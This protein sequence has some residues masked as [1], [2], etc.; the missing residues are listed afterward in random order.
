[1]IK[2][3]ELYTDSKDILT[4]IG[5]LRN[6]NNTFNEKYPSLLPR[7]SWLTHS[8]IMDTHNRLYLE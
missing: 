2:K 7:E 3:L 5:R 8:I 4:C 1:M 6:A